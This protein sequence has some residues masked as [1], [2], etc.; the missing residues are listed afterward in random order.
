MIDYF[1]EQFGINIKTLSK[2]ELISLSKENNLNLE[3]KV[4]SVKAFVLNGQIYINTSNA[5]AEDLFHEL[6][7]IFLGILKVS[8]PEAYQ[9]LIKIYQSK[10][11]YKYQYITHRKT[12][13]HYA[14]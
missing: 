3:N 2:D 11:D 6:S 7:H 10:K 12:Y 5:N 14:D 13:Q 4:D 1:N 8:N 9:E